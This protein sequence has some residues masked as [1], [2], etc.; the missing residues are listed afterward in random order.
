MWWYRLLSAVVAGALATAGTAAQ[1]TPLSPSDVEDGERLFMNA[2]ANCHGPDG[3]SVPGVDLGHG[4]FRRA[5]SD[6]DL[7]GI[8]RRGIPGTSMPPGNYSNTQATQITAYLRSLATAAQATLGHGDPERGRALVEGKGGCLACHAIDG[9]GSRIGPDISDVGRVRRTADLERAL[10]D[11]APTVR[12][13][14]RRVKVVTRDGTVI[15]GR[16]LNH[17]TFTVQLIDSNERLRSFPKSGLREIA[18]MQT[19]PKKSYRGVLTD[20]EIADVVSY[21]ATLKGQRPVAP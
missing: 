13:Q 20:P 15:A 11:P 6:A 9:K 21:L 2:C 10:I 16:L 3:D 19:S 12:P 8:I 18:F 4:Q 7:A 5:A 1:Q 14:N 17:D